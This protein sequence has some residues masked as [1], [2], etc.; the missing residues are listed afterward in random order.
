MLARDGANLALY[1]FDGPQGYRRLREF[2]VAKVAGR[3]AIKCSAEDVLITSGSGQGI[4]L[5]NRLLLEP[6]RHG[7]PRGVHLWRSADQAQQ[8]WRQRHRRAAR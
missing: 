3:P 2:V 8:A 7:H 6:R 5:V 4:D 1:N